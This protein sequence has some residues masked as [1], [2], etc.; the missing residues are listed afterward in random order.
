MHNAHNALL[1]QSAREVPLIV[2]KHVVLLLLFI[3]GLFV[4]S[5]FS[6]ETLVD[7]VVDSRILGYS[8]ASELMTFR[9]LLRELGVLF[10]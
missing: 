10:L 7:L 1:E 2:A 8:F 6:L 3:V 9:I 5:G 4:H